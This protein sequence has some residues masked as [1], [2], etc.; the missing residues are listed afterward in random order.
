MLSVLRI[1]SFIVLIAALPE[2]AYAIDLRESS[3]VRFGATVFSICNFALFITA[4][5]SI[6]QF[7]WPGYNNRLPFHLFNCIFA[8]LFYCVSLPFLVDNRQYYEG[9]SALA[10]LSVVGK[11]FFSLDISSFAQWVIIASVLINILYITK[12][13]KE[14]YQAGIAQ[15]AESSTVKPLAENIAMAA[16]E[17]DT[18]SAVD[19][20]AE[21]NTGPEEEFTP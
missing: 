6:K 3:G 5:S 17:P 18:L 15:E 16:H 4:L 14:Y 1:I 12:Y 2:E 10:P 20:I 19:A 21:V 11:F 7:F 9:Y 8:I 13:R